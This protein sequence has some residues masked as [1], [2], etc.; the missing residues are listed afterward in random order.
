MVSA[1]QQCTRQTGVTVTQDVVSLREDAPQI[2]DTQITVIQ[3]SRGTIDGNINETRG[4]LEMDLKV[5][6]RHMTM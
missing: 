4:Y 5:N 1:S 6:A 2:L 3:Q